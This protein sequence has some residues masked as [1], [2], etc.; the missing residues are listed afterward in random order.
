MSLPVPDE[1]GRWLAWIE[2]TA[3]NGTP[4]RRSLTFYGLPKELP[5][6]YA[7][8]LTIAFPHFPGPNAPAALQE[9]QAEVLRLANDMLLRTLSWTARKR[10]S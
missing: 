7:P 6:S 9:H 4:L 8:D 5:S 2:G 10:P 3:P 1:P